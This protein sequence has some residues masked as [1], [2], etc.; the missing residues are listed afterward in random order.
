M[1]DTPLQAATVGTQLPVP[2]AAS[3]AASTLGSAAV[4]IAHTATLSPVALFLQADT[5]VKTV[6]ILLILASLWA[7]GVIAEKSV[8]LGRLNRRSS[9]LLASLR[10]GFS[11]RELGEKL[12]SFS[13]DPIASIYNAIADEYRRSHEEAPDFRDIDQDS[14]KDRIHRI[15]QLSTSSELEHLQKG[16]QGLATIGSVAPFVGLFGTVWGIMNSFQG[17]AATNNTSLAVVAPGIAEALFATALGLVAAIPS[18]VAYNRLSGEIG[19]YAKRLTTFT[20]LVEVELSRELSNK[21][22][23]DGRFAA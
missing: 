19:R 6:I 14:F 11:I 20:G 4:D 18:V 15:S 17:I 8:R 3:Q 5:V 22:V 13:K 12:Q 16:L 10:K 2:D 1:T 21:K 9:S 23:H 7:W